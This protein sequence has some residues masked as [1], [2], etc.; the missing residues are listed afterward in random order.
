MSEVKEFSEKF[1]GRY[2]K[3]VGVK[4]FKFPTLPYSGLVIL[5]G[6]AILIGF[7]YQQS[8]FN[9]AVANLGSSPTLAENY[10]ETAE[11]AA[12]ESDYELAKKLYSQGMKFVGN[13]ERVLGLA[14]KVW[15][16]IYPEK[17]LEMKIEYWKSVVAEQPTYRDGLLKLAIL[18]MR[19]DDKEQSKEYWGKA[20]RIDPNNEKVK[21]VGKII[22]VREV[23]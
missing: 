19:V 4:K 9:K 16:L 6:L 7:Y 2:L 10:L 12:S 8:A 22:Q 13:D 3:I 21:E 23:Q 11:V 5:L 15:E 20:A 14:S 18:Y 1:V 17:V